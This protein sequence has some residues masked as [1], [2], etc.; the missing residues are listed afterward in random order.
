[1]TTAVLHCHY[2]MD[3]LLL[4]SIPTTKRQYYRC[5]SLLLLRVITTAVP[6]SHCCMPP[7]PL[8]LNAIIAHLL[9]LRLISIVVLIPEHYASFPLLPSITIVVPHS[10]CSAPSLSLC[11]CSAIRTG[12]WALDTCQIPLRAPP[13]GRSPT[14]LGVRPI[15]AYQ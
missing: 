6:L 7:L 12:Q 2:C 1:M 8:H 4:C 3:L 5:A 9:P 13:N 10:H 11:C 15:I 14:Y